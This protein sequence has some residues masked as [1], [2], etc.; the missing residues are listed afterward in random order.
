[1]VTRERK[2]VPSKKLLPKE[3]KT[4]LSVSFES[5]A[6]ILRVQRQLDDV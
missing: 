6:I 3:K 4:I 5:D 1:M 2:A